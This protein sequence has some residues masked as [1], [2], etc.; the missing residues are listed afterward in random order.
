MKT[1]LTKRILFFTLHAEM[2][3]KNSNL[4]VGVCV[5]MSNDVVHTCKTTLGMKIMTIPVKEQKRWKEYYE[6]SQKVE[7]ND[8]EMENRTEEIIRKLEG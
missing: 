3:L 7:L 5:C 8:G 4:C 2:L 1:N 6:M